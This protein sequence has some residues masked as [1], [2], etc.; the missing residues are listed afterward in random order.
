[1]KSKTREVARADYLRRGNYARPLSIYYYAIMTTDND[2]AG[3]ISWEGQ[4][5]Q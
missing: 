4:T 3:S 1:M 5:P 2:T